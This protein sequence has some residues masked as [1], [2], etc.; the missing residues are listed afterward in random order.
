MAI[1]QVW[2]W[3]SAR[4]A[5]LL[6]VW[7]LIA[8]IAG[9]SPQPADQSADTVSP[10]AAFES[11]M[12]GHERDVFGYLW[13]L[14]GD[15]QTAYDLCQ[16]TF[17][18]AWQHYA[19]MSHYEQPGAWLFRVATNLALNSLKKRKLLTYP[20]DDATE[21]AQPVAED[22]L[23]GFVVRDLVHRALLQLQPRH[24]SALVL[25]EVYGLSSEEV[26]LALGTTHAAAKMTLSRAREEFRQRVTYEEGRL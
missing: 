7:R 23:H 18:R 26:A 19:T 16:E 13:R 2:R 21:G 8:Q 15:E 6:T 5:R 12:R 24:R 10:I 25:R 1:A 9:G 17:L 22:P 14:T 20:A 3:E 11:L 4:R